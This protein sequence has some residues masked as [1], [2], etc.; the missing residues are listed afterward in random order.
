MGESM[1]LRQVLRSRRRE[2]AVKVFAR[3]KTP[4][5]QDHWALTTIIDGCEELPVR[6]R[7]F[8]LATQRDS[9]WPR[10]LISL[11]WPWSA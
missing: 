6:A 7:L 5:D 10:I 1:T 3:G 8:F 11:C 9:A 2:S 4:V